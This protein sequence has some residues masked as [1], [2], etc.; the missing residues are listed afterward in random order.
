MRRI[1]RAA[2]VATLVPLLLGA[3]V[4]AATQFVLG[5]KLIIANAH[6]EGTEEEGY[7][8][9]TKVQVRA[10]GS[11]GTIVDPSLSGTEPSYLYIVANGATSTATYALLNP[12]FWRPVPGGFAYKDRCPRALCGPY[13]DESVRKLVIKKGATS[14]SISMVLNG[15]Y[16]S[17]AVLPPNPGDNGGVVLEIAGGDSYCVAFGGSA[18]GVELA[19]GATKWIVNRPTAE[20]PCPCGPRGATC[21]GASD[22]CASN[23]TEGTCR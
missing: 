6:P 17:L 14:F 11:D 23:C 7:A 20:G 22:C 3:P 19:D 15:K 2:S 10:R 18:G 1:V 12:D 21:S 4:R 5:Q 13:S 16:E 8:H 9:Y